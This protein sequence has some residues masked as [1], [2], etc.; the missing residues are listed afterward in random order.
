MLK[1][2][3][4]FDGLLNDLPQVW[5]DWIEEE[6]GRHFE[7]KDIPDYSYIP[8]VV[9]ER[10]VSFWN[11]PG[12]YSK[13]SPL[14]GAVEFVNALKDSVGKANVSICTSTPVSI[15]REKDAFIMENFGFQKHQIIHTP[16]KHPFTRGSVLLEDYKLNAIAH[17]VHNRE[18]A[19]L[20]DNGGIYGWAKLLPE[21]RENIL[22]VSTYGEILSTLQKF[23][24]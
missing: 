1:V 15:I 2:V 20:F 16:V 8:K 24:E 14:P 6:F 9:G 4:D 12:F 11:T 18:P 7:L 13:V 21:E 5:V 23:L 10:A 17:A 3:C 19:I 22:T